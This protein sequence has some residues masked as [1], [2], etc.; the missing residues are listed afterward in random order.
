VQDE[1]HAVE[2]DHEHP[3]R[4]ATRMV[5][6][7]GDPMQV[8]RLSGDQLPGMGLS[9]G[10]QHQASELASET[11]AALTEDTLLNFATE[12]FAVGASEPM[13]LRLL[14]IISQATVE[15]VYLVKQ[16]ITK[17]FEKQRKSICRSPERP[18]LQL[19]QEEALG[20]FLS[21]MLGIEILTQEVR[22]ISER[23]DYYV[24]QEKKAMEKGK[25]HL[26]SKK[27]SM[28][29]AAVKDASLAANLDTKLAGLETDVAGERQGRRNRVI[30]D[31]LELPDPQKSKIVEPR[32]QRKADDVEDWKVRGW[33]ILPPPEPE[34]REL[35][36]L[37][38]FMEEDFEGD[39]AEARSGV[40][41]A[42]TLLAAANNK[43]TRAY[44]RLV[45]LGKQPSENYVLG[46]EPKYDYGKKFPAG[47]KA[48]REGE[49]L[50]WRT[51]K[52]SFKVTVEEH[53]E[54]RVEA[55]LADDKVCEV[56]ARQNV[57][58]RFK[59]ECAE[60]C[61]VIQEAKVA[62]EK[63]AIQYGHSHA[64]LAGNQRLLEQS[65]ARVADYDALLADLAGRIAIAE[66]AG[67]LGVAEGQPVVE[68]AAV[69]VPAVSGVLV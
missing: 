11:P 42:H 56:Q 18:D 36:E 28:R 23:V 61:R 63:R 39:L 64:K 21:A 17:L 1:S 26:K 20:Y 32:V 10:G 13:V 19:S 22:K 57:Q 66:A 16:A 53:K 40:K 58:Q 3:D 51:A 68:G 55:E 52:L 54:A 45:K 47:V 4:N 14:S 46:C 65:N 29:D 44:K 48:K 9:F 50:R 27:K 38:H 59:T 2:E 31:K 24:G 5:E 37:E 62:V 25:Q 6:V 35:T 8:D 67:E 15:L 49:M 34:E 41:A 69:E 7:E 60:K 30:H 12:M 33:R 43:A